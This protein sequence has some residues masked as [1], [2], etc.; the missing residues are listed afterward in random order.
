MEHAIHN[1][2]PCWCWCWCCCCEVLF[3]PGIQRRI[4]QIS[5]PQRA[6]HIWGDKSQLRFMPYI[7]I[8]IIFLPQLINP[9]FLISFF[10]IYIVFYFGCTHSISKFLGQGLNLSHSCDLQLCW[11]LSTHGTKRRWNLCLHSNLSRF[12][13]YWNTVGTPMLFNIFLPLTITSLPRNS[14]SSFNMQHTYYF[15]HK[16]L[17]NSLSI[18]CCRC[19]P[20]AVYI[21]P[22]IA[23]ARLIIKS[24]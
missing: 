10:W 9:Y 12:L 14:Y 15:V 17:L 13:T 1:L 11:T 19:V 6:H 7:P 4:G 2:L 22:C 16:I 24:A 8:H 3:A 20:R 23:L 5:F 21:S 18:I